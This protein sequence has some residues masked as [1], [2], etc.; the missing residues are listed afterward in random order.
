MALGLSSEFDYFAQQVVASDIEEEYDYSVAT[1]QAIVGKQPLEFCIPAEHEVYRDLNNSLLEVTCKVE[2]ANGDNLAN[3]AAVAPI[4]LVLHSLFKSCEVQLNGKRVSDANNYYA[5]RAY[6]E[7]VLNCPDEILKT[8][9]V[10]EGWANDNSERM[11][12]ILVAGD[13]NAG[14]MK[15]RTWSAGSKVMKFVGRLHSDLFHQPLDIPSSVKIDIK[16]DQNPDSKILMAAANAT[17]RVTIQAAR[18]LVRSKRLST[19]LVLAHQ[20]FLG[21]QNYRLPF[22]RVVMKAD[23]V[24]AGVGEVTRSQFHEGPMPSRITIFMVK[25]TSTTGAYNEN[26]FMFENF[27]KTQVRLKIGKTTY[28]HDEVITDYAN[29][30]YNTAYIS[31]LA[32]LGLDQGNRALA[33]TPEDWA[34]SFNVYSFKLTPGAINPSIL[35]AMHSQQVKIDLYVKFAAQLTNPITIF[36]YIEEPALLEIDNL[37]NVVA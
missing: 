28:P 26:P 5:E 21:N 1:K 11:A 3:D 25:S 24:G 35:H 31:T 12:A 9:G 23:S 30:V 19:D 10:C 16:L 34:R 13:T 32:A 22:T 20:K 36:A 17:F 15:R 7:T 6:L 8:R 18:L 4:N 29:G 27:G 33:I 14:F 2:Q 37:N